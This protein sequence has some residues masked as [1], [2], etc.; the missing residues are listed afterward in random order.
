MDPLL[1]RPLAR[2]SALQLRDVV[3]ACF[4]RGHVTA[5]ARG[6]ALQ[7]PPVSRDAFLEKCRLNPGRG[8]GCLPMLNADI[9]CPTA[10]HEA[11]R[12]TKLLE[13][14]SRDICDRVGGVL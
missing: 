6:S 11:Q 13:I 12:P 7:L 3:P 5:Q 4:D 10:R 14:R 8:F 2:Q 9:R 1:L